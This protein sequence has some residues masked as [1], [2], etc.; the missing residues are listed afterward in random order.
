MIM[1]AL[2]QFG[3]VFPALVF[4]FAILLLAPGVSQAQ[5]LLYGQASGQA[6]SNTDAEAENDPFARA[7]ELAAEKG[8]GVI[9]VDGSGAHLEGAG[10]ADEAGAKSDKMEGASMRM[11][12]Q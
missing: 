5:T 2:R 9:I 6:S 3:R 12:A 7:I 10:A 11:K 1:R 4:F 8:V